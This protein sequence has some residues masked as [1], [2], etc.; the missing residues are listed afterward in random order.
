MGFLSA[1]FGC[2]S[3]EVI[4][5]KKSKHFV[6]DTETNEVF[7]KYYGG[8]AL[9]ASYRKLATNHPKDMA[10]LSKTFATDGHLVFYMNA[11]IEEASP[12][13]F[14]VNSKFSDCFAKNNISKTHY[15]QD[16][17]LPLDYSSAKILSRN[18][19]LDKNKV[20]FNNKNTYDSVFTK[21]IPV[22][23][24]SS[25][26]LVNNKNNN[27][28][29]KDKY[30]F[31]L[32]GIKLPVLSKGAQVIQVGFPTV[33][34][35][36]D[37]LH[38]IYTSNRSMANM[39]KHLL[40]NFKVTDSVLIAKSKYDSYYHFKTTGLKN[41]SVIRD[42]YWVK[43]ANGLYYAQE[44][45]RFIEFSKKQFNSYTYNSE[46]PKYLR[47]ENTL[48]AF[49]Y[50]GNSMFSNAAKIMNQ[51]IVI[52]NNTV[53]YEGI[54]VDNCDVATFTKLGSNF[55]DKNYYYYSS[56]VGKNR[57][58]IPSWAYEELTNGSIKYRDFY[59]VKMGSNHTEYK[60][61]WNGFL[62]TMKVPTVT[63][64]DRN[65]YLE[66]KNI[67]R[68]TLKLEMPLEDKI[69]LY[70]NKTHDYSTTIDSDYKVTLRPS[71]AYN[72]QQIAKEELITF[73]TNVPE[74][75][76]D[77][78]GE[79]FALPYFVTLS[80]TNKPEKGQYNELYIKSDIKKKL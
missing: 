58:P 18:Y 32:K 31:Y 1:L 52:D 21:E 34:L 46:F 30:W 15:Y 64:I 45:D 63:N 48:F 17:L 16:N 23:D 35:Q 5:A 29:A 66:F 7:Y 71:E 59:D 57:H 75:V 72:Y 65:L 9:I 76:T 50:K 8:G 42:S 78:N 12:N 10:I 69:H 6:V 60:E 41:A 47:T 36:K 33:F 27:L 55:I 77:S 22:Q 80:S 4:D 39:R 28:L 62:V 56:G 38:S 74:N 44:G 25:F 73:T 43:D 53:F 79:Q 68:K 20:L 11:I 2:S 24:V 54:E 26:E 67:E 3:K 14:I 37:T 70:F 61:Y 51:D 13:G 49:Y 40:P 19:V